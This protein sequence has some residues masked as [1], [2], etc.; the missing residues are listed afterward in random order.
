[1]LRRSL[2][3]VFPNDQTGLDHTVDEVCH[4]V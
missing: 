3:A 1:M 4:A 2:R